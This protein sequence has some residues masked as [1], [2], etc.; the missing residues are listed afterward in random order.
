MRY[1][2]CVCVCVQWVMYIEEPIC[3]QAAVEQM[4]DFANK[5]AVS[6]IICTRSNER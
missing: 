5:T 3:T 1:A 6:W 2:M 4:V